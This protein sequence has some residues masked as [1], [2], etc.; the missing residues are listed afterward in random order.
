MQKTFCCSF[1]RFQVPRESELKDI[2]ALGHCDKKLNS[3]ELFIANR[4]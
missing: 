3:R 2:A 4:K 1:Y